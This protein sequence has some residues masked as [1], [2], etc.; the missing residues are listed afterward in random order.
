MN[1]EFE[2]RVYDV[3]K[4]MQAVRERRALQKIS[5]LN[6]EDQTFV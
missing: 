4:T 2:D 5:K 1:R 3:A 6:P